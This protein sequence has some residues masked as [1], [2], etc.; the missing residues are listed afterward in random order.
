MVEGKMPAPWYLEVDEIGANG[1]PTGAKTKQGPYTSQEIM[2]LVIDGALKVEAKIY[3][4]DANEW[5]IAA[6]VIPQLDL[7]PPERASKGWQAPPRPTELRDFHIVDLNRQSTGNIDYFALVAERNR[8]ARPRAVS[9]AGENNSSKESTNASSM[10]KDG[11]TVLETERTGDIINLIRNP[12][13]FLAKHKTSLAVAASVSVVFIGTYHVMRT[14]SENRS[15]EPA[16]APVAAAQ[17]AKNNAATPVMAP[18]AGASLTAD[19]TLGN[20]RNKIQKPNNAA[21]TR[22]QPAPVAAFPAPPTQVVEPPRE[23]PQFY[24]SSQTYQQGQGG[25]PPLPQQGMPAAPMSAPY[26][27]PNSGAVDP[28]GFIPPPGMAQPSQMPNGEQQGAIPGYGGAPGMM[29]GAVAP[30]I[31]PGGGAAPA[32]Q[33]GGGTYESSNDPY[34]APGATR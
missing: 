24:S 20:G 11:I 18:Q 31:I 1:A 7:A 30:G 22:P 27:D 33:Q 23:P 8:N 15:R 16:N 4:S 26:N 34:R 6:D 13:T 17:P 19:N 32:Y 9:K 5:R 28:P 12:I 10:K 29:P 3:D 2:K 14:I 25:T 21:P